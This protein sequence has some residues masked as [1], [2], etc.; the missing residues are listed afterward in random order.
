MENNIALNLREIANKV[1]EE[2]EQAK[3]AL[4]RELVEKKIIP[5]L[6]EF[7]EKG[8]YQVDFSVPGYSIQLVRDILREIGFTA[9]IHKFSNSYYL[10]VKW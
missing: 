9:E 2:A 6:Q 4:H 5:Y 8:K 10:I 3:V 7:A 1:N